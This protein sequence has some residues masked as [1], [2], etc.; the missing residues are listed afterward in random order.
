MGRKPQYSDD[1]F[2]DAALELVA[3]G[4]P[5]AATAVAIARQ[6]GAPSGSVYHRFAST[7][8]I[9]ARL[10][11]RTIKRFQAGFIEALANP[12]ATLGARLAAQHLLNF[13]RD[14]ENETRLML[15]HRREDLAAR[16]PDE[17]GGELATLNDG[18]EAAIRDYTVRRFGRATSRRLNLV[19]FAVVDLPYAA[20]RRYLVRAKVPPRTMDAVVLRAGEA[21]LCDPALE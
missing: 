16:W 5:R 7:D 10:W 8:L 6:V 4:G 15:L 3:A 20:V 13:S 11:I 1:D 9:L 14:S 21:L 19:A 18:V 2:L 12:D 17:L